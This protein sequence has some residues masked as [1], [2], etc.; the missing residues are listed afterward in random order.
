LLRDKEPLV[1]PKV[2]ISLRGNCQD[3][4]R[5]AASHID[6]A[7]RRV[8]PRVALL[9]LAWFLLPV[10]E[11]LHG[12]SDWARSLGG[13]GLALISAAYVL[14]TLIFVPGFPMTLAVAL[15]YGW[16]AL[17]ICFIGGML[18]ALIS[19][20]VGRHL[21]RD[22]VKRF[23]DKHP[24]A[25]AVDSVAHDE[26]FKTILLARLTPVTPFAVENYAFG[27]T[28]VRLGAYLVATAVGIV[29]GTILNVWIGI[30]GRTAA[31]GEASVANWSLL[32]IGLL[33]TIVLTVWMT[34]QAK[35]KLNEQRS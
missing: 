5:V 35:Q 27:V 14:G 22:F 18:A 31:Q 23:L 11:W 26:T 32:I 17:A 6:L 1:R 3:G 10:N 20:L 4:R 28:G 29:P 9:L 12:F 24:A 13:A 33:A 19:F 15:V 8:G 7:C 30:I 25:K 2:L 21:A 16:W 34:R